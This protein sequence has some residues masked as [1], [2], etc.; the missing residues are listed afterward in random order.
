MNLFTNGRPWLC[1]SAFCIFFYALAGARQTHF[2]SIQDTIDN[3]VR[4]WNSGD[5]E[6]FVETYSDDAVFVGKPVLQL[7]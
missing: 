1:V 2:D 6:K 5:L 7:Y 3:Q 4:A